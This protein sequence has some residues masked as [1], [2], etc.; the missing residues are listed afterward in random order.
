MSKYQIIIL[1][2]NKNFYSSF[3]ENHCNIVKIVQ[4]M[5]FMEYWAYENEV[6]FPG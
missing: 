6:E 1:I 5:V 4:L 3:P 2:C